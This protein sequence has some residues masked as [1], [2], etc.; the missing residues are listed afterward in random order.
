MAPGAWADVEAGRALYHAKPCSGCH[1]IG[2]QG[3]QIGPNLTHE[4]AVAGHDRDWQIRHLLA[5]AEVVPG[6]FMP[7]GLVTKEEA[8]DLA[9]YLLSL[10]GAKAAPE[11]IPATVSE[12]APE[13]VPETPEAPMVGDAGR[14]EALFGAKGCGGCHT[15]RGQGGTL[16]P[17]LTFEGETGHDA[18]WHR[19]H[20]A[21]PGAVT[22]GSTMPAFP[23]T[24]AE[25][26]DLTAFLTGL[27]H[28]EADRHMAPAL[29]ARYA[30]LG[31]LLDDLTGR[32]AHARHQGRNVDDMNVL[33]TQVGTHLSTVEEMVRKQAVGGAVDE[34]AAAEKAGSDLTASLVDFEAQLKARTHLAIG[35]VLFVLVGS[36]LLLRK[37]TLLTREWW[38]DPAN[39]PFAPPGWKSRP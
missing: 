25:T 28:T 35:F 14:G 26:A 7:A 33:L 21:D 16:G 12:V 22:P 31:P 24:P 15:I 1:T 10:G 29:A 5:P 18:A 20:F 38:D 17:D 39:A 23:L 6:S 32:V 19:R 4:G 27:V 30:A 8:G 13:A 36:L 3:G 34:V 11:A 9:D 37:I 2:G